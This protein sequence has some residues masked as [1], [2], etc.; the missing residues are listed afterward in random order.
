MRTMSPEHKEKLRIARELSRARKSAVNAEI[1][2]EVGVTRPALRDEIYRDT[3]A[4]APKFSEID[5]RDAEL[6]ALRERV[7]EFDSKREKAAHEHK[8]MSGREKIND[9]GHI[10]GAQADVQESLR[11]MIREQLAETFPERQPARKTARDTVRPNAVVA[12]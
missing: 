8:T 12:H 2:E 5:P 3:K 7:A 1:I 9:P 10:G 6:E 4:E 11:E